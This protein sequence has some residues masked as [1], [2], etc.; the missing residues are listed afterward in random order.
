MID[1]K[2]TRLNDVVGQARGCRACRQAGLSTPGF[3]PG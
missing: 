3:N 2:H 1:L